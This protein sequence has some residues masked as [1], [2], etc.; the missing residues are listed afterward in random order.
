MKE[1]SESETKGYRNLTI[2]QIE[3][4]ELYLST[5]IRRKG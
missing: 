4:N 5:V 3:L 1:E 2:K